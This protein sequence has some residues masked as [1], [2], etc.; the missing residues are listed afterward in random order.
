MKSP[1]KLTKEER[2]MLCIISTPPSGWY[3]KAI[4]L[5]SILKVFEDVRTEFVLDAILASDFDKNKTMKHIK[6][7]AYQSKKKSRTS[8][9]YDNSNRKVAENDFFIENNMF[10]ENG[11]GIEETLINEESTVDNSQR[12][13][14]LRYMIN[15]GVRNMDN[16]IEILLENSEDI[17]AEIGSSAYN[18]LLEGAR[19][20]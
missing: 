15:K 7:N 1:S 20:E 18:R 6:K 2:E 17:I 10:N 5:A 14:I 19:N 12:Y 8:V 13:A 9:K 3:D 4:K 16:Y 11:I